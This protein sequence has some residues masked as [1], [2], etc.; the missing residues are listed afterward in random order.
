MTA[1]R[2]YITATVTDARMAII[3]ACT[4]GLLTSLE[5]LLGIITGC[6]PMLLPIARRC[7]DALPRRGRKKIS[8]AA[9]A[10]YTLIERMTRFL[11]LQSIRIVSRYSHW[12]S[13]IGEDNDKQPQSTKACSP[14]EKDE[15][16]KPEIGCIHIRSDFEVES[17]FCDV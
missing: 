6:L 11:S 7:W 13:P 17:V 16:Q 10:V 14:P 3:P 1:Y 9:L 12:V 8:I 15:V 2:V 4:I 5:A